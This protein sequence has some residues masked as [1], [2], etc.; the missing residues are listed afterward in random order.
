MSRTATPSGHRDFRRPLT[1][2]FT[3]VEL[4]VVIGIIA[5]LISILLPSLNRAREAAKRTQCLSNLRQI[6]TMV[7]MYGNAYK[8]YAPIGYSGAGTANVSEANNY[9]LT[10]T[11]SQSPDGDPPRIVRYT[12]LGL[13]FKAR[14]VKEGVAGGDG[15]SGRVFYCPSFDGDRF[16]GFRSIGNAVWPPSLGTVRCSYSCRGSTDNPNPQIPGSYATDGVC[17]ATGSNAADPFAPVKVTNGR[18]DRT[19]IGEMF[20]LNKLKNKAIIADVVSSNTRIRPAHQKGINVLFASGNARWVDQ[21]LFK[22]QLDWAEKNNKDMFRKEQD[23]LHHQIWK[24]FDADNV[25]YKP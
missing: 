6:M 24:N 3:L 12:A 14:L 5:V 21:G 9:Y 15:G 4:L 8:G 1:H 22:Q 20:R 11:A 16:H 25:V 17:W 10:R 7:Q 19:Q 2:A 18:T 13:L 23:Y